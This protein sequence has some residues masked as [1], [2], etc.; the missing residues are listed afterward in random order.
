MLLMR[1]VFKYALAF[2]IS[3]T[4]AKSSTK[5]ANA[6]EGI[7]SAALPNDTSNNPKLNLHIEID[8]QEVGD[9]LLEILPNSSSSEEVTG[10]NLTLLYK[11][12]ISIKD[13]KVKISTINSTDKPN[14]F[15]IL[16]SYTQASHVVQFITFP[17]TYLRN[18][19]ESGWSYLAN[20]FVQEWK[21]DLNKQIQADLERA[22]FSGQD[23]HIHYSFRPTTNFAHEN[24]VDYATIRDILHKRIDRIK[25]S[26]DGV[27]FKPSQYSCFLIMRGNKLRGDT[28]V[29]TVLFG[30]DRGVSTA[31]CSLILRTAYDVDVKRLFWHSS[32]KYLG[33]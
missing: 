16:N 6:V 24:L 31:V 15:Q 28:W 25:Q 14:I 2:I 19:I 30:G 5:P 17:I 27:F 22:T 29:G 12:L 13:S 10:D 4:F 21:K 3:C 32:G 33:T 9:D 20:E 26:E 11:K 8:L 23:G 7:T 18:Q 1:V